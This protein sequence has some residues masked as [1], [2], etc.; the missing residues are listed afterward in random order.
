MTDII[1]IAPYP[2][3]KNRNTLAYRPFI[4]YKDIET[5]IEPFSGMWGGWFEQGTSPC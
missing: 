2:G 5:Y 4:P 3:G 1:T